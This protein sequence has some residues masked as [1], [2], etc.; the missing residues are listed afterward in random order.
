MCLQDVA[1]GLRL[2]SNLRFFTNAAAVQNVLGV[3]SKRHSIVLGHPR[4][5]SVFYSTSPNVA[6]PN[7]ILLQSSNNN[8]VYLSRE[9]HG[10]IVGEA[11]Y[12]IATAPAT[13]LWVIEST[14]DEGLYRDALREAEKL[15]PSE[16]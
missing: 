5:G 15:T 7:G 14:M 3:N 4:S 10:S 13:V 1:I 16:V 12:A 2:K 9:Q 6:D 8:D 11:W